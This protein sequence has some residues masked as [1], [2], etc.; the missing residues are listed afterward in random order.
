MPPPNDGSLA[1]LMLYWL[2][3]AAVG[4]RGWEERQ[5][6]Q[7]I[8]D[9]GPPDV[10]HWPAPRKNVEGFIWRVM[11]MMARGGNGPHQ[12]SLLL[13]IPRWK[14]AAK[15]ESVLVLCRQ[16]DLIKEASE[17]LTRPTN[18][19][20]EWFFYL[21]IFTGSQTRSF[22]WGASKSTTQGGIFDLNIYVTFD[23]AGIA[24]FWKHR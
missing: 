3:S 10:E 12:E 18:W 9:G 8:P 20:P 4:G 21:Y 17:Y 24:A 16:L 6:H 23:C 22:G 15:R 1:V 19:S 14:V 11:E 5:W 13:T 2:V 7:R